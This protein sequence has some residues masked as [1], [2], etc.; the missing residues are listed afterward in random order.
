MP[1]NDVIEPD[2]ATTAE[3]KIAERLAPVCRHLS[4]AQFRELVRNVAETRRR[5]ERIDAGLRRPLT[6]GDGRPMR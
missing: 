4:P 1:P 2:F 5:L 6:E 3:R